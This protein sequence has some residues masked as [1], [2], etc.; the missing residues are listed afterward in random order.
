ML[1]IF[2]FHFKYVVNICPKIQTK[3]LT[4]TP[5]T[6]YVLK[7][8]FHGKPKILYLMSKDKLVLKKSCLR[9]IFLSF[10]HKHKK[11]LVF[12]KLDVRT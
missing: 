12:S 1:L 11:I 8:S 4:R 9:D 7:K 5:L 6:F 10:L 3:I 2:K